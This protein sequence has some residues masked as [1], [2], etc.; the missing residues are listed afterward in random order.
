MS[1]KRRGED[2][3]SRAVTSLIRVLT[4]DAYSESARLNVLRHLKFVFS[5][6]VR[7]LEQNIMNSI[8]I[9]SLFAMLSSANKDSLVEHSTSYINFL[10]HTMDCDELIDKSKTELIQFLREV[11]KRKLTLTHEIV[12]NIWE[13]LEKHFILSEELFLELLPHSKQFFEEEVIGWAKE[14]TAG[15]NLDLAYYAEVS[16][17]CSCLFKMITAMLNTFVRDTRGNNKML[18]LVEK[19]T[20]SVNNT[21]QTSGSSILRLYPSHYCRLISLLSIPPGIFQS[22][23]QTDFKLKLTKDKVLKIILNHFNED[24]DIVLLFLTHFPRWL[25]IFA[26]YYK[27]V[28]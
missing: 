24:P 23:L 19:Y 9:G 21:C 12:Q 20:S 17:H 6:G 11:N 26:D 28:L 14:F 7:T 13:T 8:P 3:D 2:L 27:T 25:D 15:N 16:S 4:D 1:G 22:Q 10:L 18:D 5:K